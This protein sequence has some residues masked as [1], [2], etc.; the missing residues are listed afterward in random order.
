MK[1]VTRTMK[2][3]T[4]TMTTMTCLLALGGAAAQER[5]RSTAGEASVLL[6]APRP[7]LELS[8][9]VI[10]SGPGTVT[11]EGVV[12]R[13][14]LTGALSARFELPP[15][16]QLAGGASA[17]EIPAEENPGESVLRAE[18]RCQGIPPEDLRLVVE[19]REPTRTV[20]ATRRYRFGRPPPVDVVVHRTGPRRTLLGHDV[21][22]TVQ[23]LPEAPAR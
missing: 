17:L 9:R 21:G 12:T 16:C 18:L 11:L 2:M 6:V 23:L 10:S 8:V 14:T 22:P 4:R 1:D 19:S 20:H 7:P 13:R 3:M 15:E 5:L